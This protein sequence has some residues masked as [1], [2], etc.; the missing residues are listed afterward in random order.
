MSLSQRAIED[1]DVQEE[2][3]PPQLLLPPTLNTRDGERDEL[4]RQL[5][6]MEI[7]SPGGCRW[8]FCFHRHVQCEEHSL[9]AGVSQCES[10]IRDTKE[11]ERNRRVRNNSQVSYPQS[12]SDYQS[13]D[14]RLSI[15]VTPT[16][17]H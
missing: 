13:D 14:R 5:R 9:E 1:K 11:P 16:P 6:P 12:R 15:M 10:V 4:C 3:L 17:V 8:S 2:T 7:D